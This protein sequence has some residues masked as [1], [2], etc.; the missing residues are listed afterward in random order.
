MVY[1]RERERNRY[2][3]EYDAE[4]KREMR[5]RRRYPEESEFT[6]RGGD[7]EREVRNRYDPRRESERRYQHEDD[8]P[9]EYTQQRGKGWGEFYGESYDYES[10]YARTGRNPQRRGTSGDYG[11]RRYPE[12]SQS[13]PD[14]WR[15]SEPL[16]SRQWYE[17]GDYG[18]RD[19]YGENLG[20]SYAGRGP[21]G[22]QRS[23]ERIREDVNESLAR[24]HD[25]DPSDV[26]IN[27]KSGEVTLEGTIDNRWMKR[28]ME[29]VVYSIF[30]V[31]EVH[32]RVRINRN[33]NHEAIDSNGTS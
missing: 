7:G 19:I 4:D 6:R 5:R 26:E 18:V 27:V 21:K 29:D 3:D 24:H 31:Q 17:G 13:H 1:N 14:T 30:G 32:N 8:L 16:S 33:N 25:I 22:W 15:I 9:Y 12:E 11:Y 23:D 2:R 28:H 20:N 10:D